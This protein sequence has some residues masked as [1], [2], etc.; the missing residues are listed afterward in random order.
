MLDA[1]VTPDLDLMAVTHKAFYVQ[2]GQRIAAALLPRL[3]Q[4]GR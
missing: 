3:A 1:P 2:P 4:V